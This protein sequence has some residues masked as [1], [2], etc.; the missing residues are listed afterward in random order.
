VTHFAVAPDMG[1]GTRH[2]ELGRELARL[3]WDVHI[4]AE[5]GAALPQEIRRR[6]Q[7]YRDRLTRAILRTAHRE[8]P[9]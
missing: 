9:S 4:A 1:G 3:G 7:F 6:P 8:P 5:E 2:V